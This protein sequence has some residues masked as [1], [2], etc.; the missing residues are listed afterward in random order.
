MTWTRIITGACIFDGNDCHHGADLIVEAGRQEISPK[1][2]EFQDAEIVDATG[3][4]LRPGF[5]DLQV[6]GG[7]GALFNEQPTLE[8]IR[9]I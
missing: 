9:Q 1:S 6:N 3:L 2:A 7:G 5:I 4:L 8:G